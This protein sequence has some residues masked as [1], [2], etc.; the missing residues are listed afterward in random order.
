[1]PWPIIH[2]A[3]AYRFRPTPAFLLGS[4]A[5]DAVLVKKEVYE[6]KV[7]SHLG[8]NPT[9]HDYLEFLKSNVNK[10]KFP[11]DHFDFF[12]G[13]IAHIYGLYLKISA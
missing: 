3:I 6:A 13:Y 11:D 12:L 5:P 8:R 7:K 2:F 4:V 1:M 9:I 10:N